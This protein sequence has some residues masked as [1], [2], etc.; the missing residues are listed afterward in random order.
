MKKKNKDKEIK[1]LKETAQIIQRS[2][3]DKQNFLFQHFEKFYKI[4][5]RNENK[6]DSFLSEIKTKIN[7]ED[8]SELIRPIDGNE[9]KLTVNEMLDE[10]TPGVDGFPAEFFKTFYEYLK[11]PLVQLYN[12]ILQSG[13][14]PQSFKTGAIT[15]IFKGR[16][17]DLIKNWRPISLLCIDYKILAKIITNR[18]K[19]H[20]NDIIN[21]FQ[22]G[23]IPDRNIIDNLSGL[24]NVIEDANTKSPGAILSLDYK[25]LSIE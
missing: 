14:T 1:T 6:F 3:E 4:E 13:I 8:N 9:L 18:L 17:K 21:P 12:A 19:K 11:E 7:D 23:A 25:K 10:K 15:L 20:F 2:E 5:P 22:T 16:G 24:R